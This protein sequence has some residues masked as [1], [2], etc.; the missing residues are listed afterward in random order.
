MDEKVVT[1]RRQYDLTET[2]E[3]YTTGKQESTC[4]TCRET[5][6]DPS[7]FGPYHDASPRCES[8]KRS[9]CSC[10]TCF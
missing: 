1:R 3:S 2:T 4:R 6:R 5:Q 9:H 8:G 10:D 7:H